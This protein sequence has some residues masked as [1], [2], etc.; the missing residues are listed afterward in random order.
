MSDR[1]PF[2]PYPLPGYADSL[3][4]FQPGGYLTLVSGTPA[5]ASDQASKTI[6]YYTQDKHNAFPVI[7]NGTR[8]AV[9]F[10]EP[11]L[12]LSAAHTA[13]GICDVF[14][15]ERNGKGHIVTGPLWSTATAGSGARGTGGGTTELARVGGMLVN[16]WGVPGLNGDGSQF[17]APLEGAYLG[18]LFF[19]GS[20]GQASCHVSHSQNRKWGVWNAY[21]R[22]RIILLAGDSTTSWTY[23]VATVRA[24][25]GSSSNKATAFTGL[26]DER[27]NIVFRQMLQ[28]SV[29]GNACNIEIG[30]G[31]NSTTAMS[32]QR[33]AV[34]VA[35]A[36]G[37]S[38]V[39]SRVTIA[40][41]HLLQPG[42]G[43]NDLTSLETASTTGTSTA[44]GGSDDMVL[45]VDYMG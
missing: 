36:A 17:I 6:V 32:G 21:N 40:A 4:P 39:T 15:V 30:I 28:V 3:F 13:N 9:Y 5:I 11:R 34:N 45:S 26:D 12:V 1:D 7:K 27:T 2:G 22:R 8:H 33:G 42:L 19:D 14:G 18:S 25:N 10:D 43:V 38:T 23:G 41:H 31:V 37:G 29:A 20:N 24:S 35:E 16:R 44:F